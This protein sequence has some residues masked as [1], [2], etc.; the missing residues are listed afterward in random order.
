MAICTYL[1]GDTPKMNFDN[2]ELEKLIDEYIKLSGRLCK[3]IEIKYTH[4]KIFSRRVTSKYYELYL[5]FGDYGEYQIFNFPCD[6]GATI[7]TSASIGMIITWLLG[8]T[9]GYNKA[10]IRKYN[11][12][13]NRF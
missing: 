7:N 10:S 9:D 1:R 2:D 11:D 8:W 5:Q 13:R 6:D 3:V 4:K 12:N